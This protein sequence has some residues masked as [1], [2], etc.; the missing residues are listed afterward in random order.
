MLLKSSGMKNTE[1]L[2][3]FNVIDICKFTSTMF[4]YDQG[5]TV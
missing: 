3:G 4:T 2:S 5:V 1:R